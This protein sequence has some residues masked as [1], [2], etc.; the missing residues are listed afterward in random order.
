MLSQM[1]SNVMVIYS[2]HLFVCLFVCFFVCLFVCFYNFSWKNYSCT[3]FSFGNTSN[4]FSK[5]F[6][7][8]KKLLSR[9]KLN[10]NHSL[11]ELQQ[12]Y[13]FVK[14]TSLFFLP[15]FFSCSAR[16]RKPPFR[17]I[18]YKYLGSSSLL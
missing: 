13:H 18:F 4:F 11:L 16:Q 12:S 1:F 2:R 15:I 5:L 14:K 6:L 8:F 3:Y 17:R 7:Q 9:V 10:N